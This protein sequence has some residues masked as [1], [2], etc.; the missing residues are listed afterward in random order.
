MNAK[1]SK[2]ALRLALIT[3]LGLSIVWSF[4]GHADDSAD[5]YD[6][7]C[8]FEANC[9][10]QLSPLSPHDPSWAAQLDQWLALKSQTVGQFQKETSTVPMF[11]AQVRPEK[12]ALAGSIEQPTNEPPIKPA[13]I[14]RPSASKK[15]KTK[16][17]RPSWPRSVSIGK[18][19]RGWLVFPVKLETSERLTSRNHKNYGTSEMVEA[20]KSAVDAVHARHPNSPVLAVGN[21]S[22]KHG[23]RFPPHKSHQ[24]GR[25]ADIGY[26]LKV[27]HNPRRLKLARTRTLDVPR[28]WTFMES[29]LADNKVEY[30]FSDRRLMRL[31]HRHAR[32]VRKLSKDKLKAYFTGPGHIIR[33]LKGHA[34]HIHVRFHAP[35]SRAAVK[36]FVK[37]HGA[38]SLKPVPVYRRIRR[39]DTL[40]RLAKRHKTSVKKLRRWNR[41]RKSTRLRVGKKLIIGHRRPKID[42]D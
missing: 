10:S 1:T 25:D 23:G 21:L 15:A 37:R 19:N 5:I 39:G 14:D 28:T 16:T 18:P 8:E 2:I 6:L 22:R 38:N 4:V 41:L 30:I 12:Q 35:E 7:R 3:T 40:W 42:V 31:L 24:S 11:A 26:Y 32:D 20:I 9:D 36:E 34:D 29:L 13:V 33:H 17:E 27:G